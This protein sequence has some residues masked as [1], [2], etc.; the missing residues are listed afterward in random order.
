[1]NTKTT[2][3]LIALLLSGLFLAGC[4][5][6]F[7]QVTE[8]SP[9]DI[10]YTAAAQTVIA[11]FTQDVPIS[12]QPGEG[13]PPA[14]TLLPELP[15]PTQTVMP[16]ET[17]ASTL[18]PTETS[19][20]TDIPNAILEDD[21][22]DK[23]GWFTDEQDNYLF[24]FKDGGYRIYNNVLGAG[25]WSVRYQEFDD[26]RIEVDVKKLAGP[27]DGYFGVVCRFGDDGADYYA[28]VISAN[29]F[30]G[31]L[32]MEDDEKEFIES[33]VDEKGIIRRGAGDVN[34]VAG[35]CNVNRLV[36]IVNGEQLLEIYDD[37]FT[38]GD[39]GLIAGNRRTTAGIDVLFDNF[40]ILWP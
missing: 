32:K 14:D 36:L 22:S 5:V 33:G 28:L 31:V 17:P 40:A 23:T 18:T 13:E 6:P 34:R 8:E 37:T 3:L 15:E 29:G 21:F 7:A 39:I 25:Y 24:E 16:S 27:E 2:F 1:M 20:P 10:L 19:T 12:T 11:K 9:P 26:I 4:N 35:V 30:Y 38:T